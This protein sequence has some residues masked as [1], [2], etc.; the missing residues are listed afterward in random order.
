MGGRTGKSAVSHK[1]TNPHMTIL[2]WF[3]CIIL[4]VCVFAVPGVR[5]GSGSERWSAALPVAQQSAASGRQP[6]RY[7]PAPADVPGNAYTYTTFSC[8]ISIGHHFHSD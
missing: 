7:Q 5:P 8:S 3:L 6:E 2:S 4:C 1:L